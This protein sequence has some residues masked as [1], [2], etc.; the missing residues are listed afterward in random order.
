MKKDARTFQDVKIEN[1]QISAE[2]FLNYV[3]F[4]LSF[5]KRCL[6]LATACPEMFCGKKVTV[7][8]SHE[9]FNCPAQ[10]I[11]CFAMMLSGNI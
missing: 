11:C 7:P 8:K 5:A 9:G 4:E 3:K 1:C 2:L 10:N 6:A